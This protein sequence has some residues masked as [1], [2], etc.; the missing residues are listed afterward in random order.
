L[1]NGY[2]NHPNPT[3]NHHIKKILEIGE[4][5]ELCPICKGSGIFTKKYSGYICQKCKGRGKI[6]W[7]QKAMG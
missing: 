1:I 3:Y 2:A 4:G 7:I 5:E 6:D